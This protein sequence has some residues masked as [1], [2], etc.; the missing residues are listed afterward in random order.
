MII[1]L[2]LSHQT[3]PLALRERLGFDASEARYMLDQF[4]HRQ[5]PMPEHFREWAI[6]STCNRIEIYACA[7][8]GAD[9]Q[10]SLAN[11]LSQ[12]R[13]V[14]VADFES[15]LY[16]H[17]GPDAVTHLCRVAAGLESMVL[18]EPQILGQVTEAYEVA[19][20]AGAAGR[21]LSAVF[22]A[23]IRA[24]KRTHT[25]TTIG[26]HPSSISSVA[27]R[28][29]EKVVGPLTERCVL[30]VGTGEMGALATKALH[31]RGVRQLFISNR[32]PQ[33]ALDLANRYGGSAVP[34]EQLPSMLAQADIVLVSTRAAQTVIRVDMVRDAMRQ[35]ADRSLM[36]IDIAVPR[37]V[38]AEAGDIPNVH[39]IDLDELHAR[40]QDALS[41]RI[42]AVPYVEAIVAQEVAAFREWQRG[43]EALTLIADLHKKA[44]AI[45]Q[46]EL[47]RTLRYLSGLD[48]QAQQHI[49]RL[50]Q[51]LVDKLLHE[52][53]QRLRD[54]AGSDKAAEYAAT[55][56]H[57]FGLN[58]DATEQ[59]EQG[60]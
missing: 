43:T 53:T 57:L 3:T 44:E 8:E 54:E 20:A 12:A 56:R 13:G 50:T 15:H 28:L 46:R 22:Q 21:V 47:D 55:V 19:L 27:I 2:G 31:M 29:A 16:C 58:P 7:V 14:S 38:A 51:S 59:A 60:R 37:N 34:F 40:L 17:E 10:S 52:P 41:G 35:R 4:A 42:S 32:T 48:P 45:R 26:H 39:V 25:E 49:H 9:V 24:G 33:G 6:L 1:C 11:F 18:G 23:A 30:V 5:S 36:L